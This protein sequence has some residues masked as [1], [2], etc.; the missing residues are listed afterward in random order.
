MVNPVVVSKKIK[1][2]SS[3][4][5]I[6]CGKGGNDTQGLTCLLNIGVTVV[7]YKV[8]VHLNTFLYTMVKAENIVIGE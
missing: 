6:V 7:K 2:R 8:S 3:H 1:L 5:L 4:P